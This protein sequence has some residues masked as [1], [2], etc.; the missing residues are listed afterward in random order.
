VLLEDLI[1]DGLQRAHTIEH[2][3]IF[4]VLTGISYSKLTTTDSSPT[5]YYPIFIFLDG[6]YGFAYSDQPVDSEALQSAL[7]NRDV[8][9]VLF[10][11]RENLPIAV[12][13]A[14][15]DGLYSLLRKPYV[16]TG[17]LSGTLEEKTERRAR[18]ALDGVP[19]GSQ[20]LLLGPV[21]AFMKE[22]KKNGVTMIPFDL[23]ESK[24]GTSIDGVTIERSDSLEKL[25][26]KYPQTTHVYVTGMSLVSNTI[27]EIIDT[28]RKED[29]HVTM[30]LETFGRCG[31]ELVG[32]GV[33]RAFAEE[34][35]FFDYPFDTPYA[36]Y[37]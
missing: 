27:D 3:R 13:A 37:T 10:S 28:A 21:L 33:S 8:R 2:G 14:L 19:A 20:V 30:F 6:G 11:D 16:P 25:L 9:E 26:E 5:I 17:Y 23:N 1:N 4:K 7:L 24:I 29:I 15:C 35:P 36:V 34:Y 12:T 31:K 32:R 18:I 22:A